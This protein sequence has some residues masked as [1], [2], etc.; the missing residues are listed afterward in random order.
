MLVGV[1]DANGVGPGDLVVVEYCDTDAWCIVFGHSLLNGVCGGLVAD[2]YG[3]D[4]VL[5]D[6]FW[7]W[8]GAGC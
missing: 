6:G 8:V 2:Y 5:L 7:G 1:A 4:E 3:W